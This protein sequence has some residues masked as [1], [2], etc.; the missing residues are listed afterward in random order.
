M[1]KPKKTYSGQAHTPKSQKGLGDYYGTGIVA[2]I[3]TMRGDS[4]GM[5]AVSQK[6]MKKPPKSLA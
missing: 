4:M 2:K 3:G 6:Q 1:K 5:Q